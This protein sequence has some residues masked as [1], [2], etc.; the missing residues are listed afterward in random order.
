MRSHELPVNLY[1]VLPL[2]N[3]RVLEEFAKRL[4]LPSSAKCAGRTSCEENMSISSIEVQE[5]YIKSE[6]GRIVGLHHLDADSVSLID[7]HLQ[8]FLSDLTDK[9][10]RGLL[11]WL[12][13]TYRS[14]AIHRLIRNRGWTLLRVEIEQIALSR[15]NPSVNQV[16]SSSVVQWNLGKFVDYLD[17]YFQQFPDSDPKSLNEFRCVMP[18]HFTRLIGIQQGRNVLVID[19]AHR[20]VSLGLQNETV[21][22]AYVP[23]RG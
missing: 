12:S 1:L 15:I 6:I 17:S 20:A 14:N 9:K 18:V 19:G 8:Q 7:K 5:Y 4:R 10:R 3:S 23:S 11:I 16:L 2:E 13:R 21:F 22:E